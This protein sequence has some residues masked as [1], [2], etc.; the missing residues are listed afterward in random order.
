MLYKLENL[1]FMNAFRNQSIGRKLVGL[2]FFLVLVFSILMAFMYQKIDLLGATIKSIA[3][4]EIAAA[5]HIS[6]IALE[7]GRQAVLLE[8]SIRN[9]QNVLYDESLRELVKTAKVEFDAL[10]ES[11][12]SKHEKSGKI[13][14]SALKNTSNEKKKKQLLQLSS[15]ME[16]VKLSHQAYVTLGGKIFAAA[17]ENRM[18]DIDNLTREAEIAELAV[19]AISK[20]FLGMIQLN[21]KNTAEAASREEQILSSIILIAVPAAVIFIMLLAGA[22]SRIITRQ[23][24][25]SIAMAERISRGDL[26]VREIE[27]N[28]RDEAGKV[29]LAMKTMSKNLRKFVTSMA[30]SSGL[31][32]SVAREITEENRKL[33]ERTAQQV[34]VMEQTSTAVDELTRSVKETTANVIEADHHAARSRNQAGDGVEIGEEAITAIKDLEDSNKKIEQ[35]IQVIDDISFQTNLLALNAA[36]EAARA[37]E[38]GRGFAV[39]ATE[40]RSLAGRSAESAKEIKQ[41][42]H[43]S[44]ER[45]AKGSEKVRACGEAFSD[46]LKS[47]EKTAHIVSQ[48]AQASEEQAKQI[49]WVHHALNEIENIGQQNMHMVEESEVTSGT[50]AQQSDRMNQILAFYKLSNEKKIPEQ[51]SDS[52]QAQTGNILRS[53]AFKQAS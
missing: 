16:K 38:Q 13:V 17:L 25:Q 8:R 40:V 23:L 6:D 43:N 14:A 19:F 33:T 32:S 22:F 47:G 41:L 18:H 29:A 45:M 53:G 4:T 34:Q 35:I 28:T 5:K 12:N 36:V 26:T 48:I 42:I 3:E 37:G 44:A 9:G 27:I 15:Q 10:T 39:V 7:Q 20:E 31:I 51:E 49:E 46:I 11:I 24:G 21:T 1:R 2:V 30:E 50:L 52:A